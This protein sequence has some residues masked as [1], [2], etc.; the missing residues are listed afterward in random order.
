VFYDLS[1]SKSS[2]VCGIIRDIAREEVFGP[3]A[4]IIVAEDD[5][6]ASDL[7]NDTPYGL[8]ASIWTPGTSIMPIE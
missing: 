7:A 6:N 2:C 4:P 8:A 3:V 5:K 1:F